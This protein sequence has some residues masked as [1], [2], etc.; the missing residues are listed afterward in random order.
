MSALSVLFLVLPLPL[1][2]ILHKAENISF[3]KRWLEK[4][5]ELL[6][7]RFYDF[8]EITEQISSFST[9]S[10][11]LSSLLALLFVILATCYL[12]VKGPCG[13]QLWAAV[14]IAFTLHLVFCIV[15]SIWIRK[16]VP[17][18]VTAILLLPL[19]LLGLNSIWISLS[20]LEILICI[21]LAML[22]IICGF[23]V[24]KLINK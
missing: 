24:T 9:K 10:H 12:L 15:L 21:C 20:I 13:L 23:K 1:A 8:K 19:S 11:I 4:N 22:F 18:L 5:K 3:Q 7:T 6:M 16:Y 2:Y 14:F 17:G